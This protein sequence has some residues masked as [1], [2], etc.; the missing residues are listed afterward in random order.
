ME[1][2]VLKE[3]T[4]SDGLTLPV[5]SFIAAAAYEMH[6]DERFYSNPDEFQPF[7][8]SDLREREGE[9]VKYQLIATGSEYLTF[10]HGRHGWCA[11]TVAYPTVARVLIHP[12]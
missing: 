10:G 6:H 8:F 5:G 2:K 4:F 11:S 7:R 1:R 3:F 12:A 9:N